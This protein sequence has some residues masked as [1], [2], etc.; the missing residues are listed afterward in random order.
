ML[1]HYD[2]SSSS[3]IHEPIPVPELLS[4]VLPAIITSFEDLEI[5]DLHQYEKKGESEDNDDHLAFLQSIE[6]ERI[7]HNLAIGQAKK[8]EQAEYHAT[9]HDIP[10]DDRPRERLQKYGADTLTTSDLLAIILRTGTQKDNVIEMAS[11]LVAK[12]GGLS[13][14]MSASFT[15]LSMEYGLGIARKSVYHS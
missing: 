6:N 3:E 9:V 2:E 7:R 5:S 11:K 1:N 13:G 4:S 15:E 12:Y 8:D 14:L 10:I